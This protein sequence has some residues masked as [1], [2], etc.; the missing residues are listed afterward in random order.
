MYKVE[1]YQDITDRLLEKRKFIQLIMEPRQVGTTTVVKQALQAL[2][3]KIPYAAFSAD[4]IPVT[5]WT[6]RG[7]HSL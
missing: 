6:G 7:P 2:K 4:Y 3:N 5:Q 1:H